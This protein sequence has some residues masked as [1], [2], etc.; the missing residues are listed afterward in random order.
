MGNGAPGS[1]IQ[2]TAEV[3]QLIQGELDAGLAPEKI[4]AWSKSHGTETCST[5]PCMIST[6]GGSTSKNG[7]PQKGFALSSVRVTMLGASVPEAYRCGFADFFGIGFRRSFCQYCPS[8]HLH[9]SLFKESTVSGELGSTPFTSL[10][11]SSKLR[12]CLVGLIASEPRKCSGKL[13]LCDVVQAFLQLMSAPSKGDVMCHLLFT[14]FASFGWVVFSPFG[15]A[16]PLQ[17]SNLAFAFSVAAKPWTN[18]RIFAAARSYAPFG[19]ETVC[20]VAS[21]GLFACHPS[22]VDCFVEA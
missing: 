20:H 8:S 6:L 16:R 17:A 3:E 15:Q 22:D 10:P 11:E 14:L 18:L 1:L 7:C 21:D 2:L 4:A 5:A 19:L 13:M 12:L 9:A